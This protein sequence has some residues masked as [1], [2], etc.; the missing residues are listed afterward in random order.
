VKVTANIAKVT[1]GGA[2]IACGTLFFQTG[3][4]SFSGNSPQNIFYNC[5]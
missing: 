3:T 5:G 1:G 4:T 2:W